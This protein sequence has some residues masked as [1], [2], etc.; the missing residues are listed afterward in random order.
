MGDFLDTIH[1][2]SRNWHLR[3]TDVVLAHGSRVEG[4]GNPKSDVDCIVIYADDPQLVAAL[5][6]FHWRDGYQLNVSAYLPD[7]VGRLATVIN[8]IDSADYNSISSL[9]IS[10]IDRY[11]RFAHGR[12]VFNADGLVRIQRAFSLEHIQA[13]FRV[14][15]ALRCTSEL[16]NAE[17]FLEISDDER[18]ATA[19]Q[20]AFEAAVDSF[21]ASSGEFFPSR[22]WRWEKLARLVGRDSSF[23]SEAWNLKSGIPGE[24]SVYLSN[25]AEFSRNVGMLDFPAMPLIPRPTHPAATFNIRDEC[26][27]VQAKTAMYHLNAEGEYIWS[28]LNDNKPVESIIEQFGE[29]FEMQPPHA[30]GLVLGFIRRLEKLGLV[31]L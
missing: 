17:L 10:I 14:W 26:Y 16:R 24:S 3:D 15:A 5:P 13:V 9:T 18:C 2:V 11:Y 8:S 20:H 27:L 31:S 28:A 23:F 4:L 25:V 7:T 21:L 19:A 1:S 22:K 29:M 12:L 6:V 30:R